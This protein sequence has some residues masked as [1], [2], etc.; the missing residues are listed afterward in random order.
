MGRLGNF[1]RSLA[2]GD[3]RQLAADLSTQ[4][5]ASHRSRGAARA[6]RAGQGWEDRDRAQD[7]RGTW[8]RPAR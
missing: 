2:P 7:K 5:R 6:A 1:V 8:Y 3:D 4:R